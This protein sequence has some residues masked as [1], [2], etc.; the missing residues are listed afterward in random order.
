METHTVGPAP[1]RCGQAGPSADTHVAHESPPLPIRRSEVVLL[2]G[3]RT[4]PRS[5]GSLRDLLSSPPEFLPDTPS[6]TVA[7]FPAST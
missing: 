5:T 2:G 4:R 3:A 1:L 6:H 7:S